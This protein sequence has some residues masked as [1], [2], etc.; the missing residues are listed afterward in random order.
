[1][2]KLS[3]IIPFHAYGSYLEDCLKSLTKS[4]WKDFEVILVLS[5]VKEDISDITTTYG[6]L[7]DMT[8]LE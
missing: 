8:I 7:L 2:K 5:H 4:T 1:M 6:T 3:V